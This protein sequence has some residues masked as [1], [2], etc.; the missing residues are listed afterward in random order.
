MKKIKVKYMTKGRRTTKITAQ[1]FM[2][3]ARSPLGK[4]P[5]KVGVDYLRPGTLTSAFTL[6]IPANGN[7]ELIDCQHNREML[8]KITKDREVYEDIKSYNNESGKMDVKRKKVTIA[9]SY[10]VLDDTPIHE[11]I[12]TDNP[13][14]ESAEVRELKAKIAA[15]EAEKGNTPVIEPV[16]KP[17][18]NA[19]PSGDVALEFEEDDSAPLT[20]EEIKS[21]RFSNKVAPT[22]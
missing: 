16:A 1:G 13:L 18:P 21:A 8:R 10:Q 5:L 17:A 19:T 20:K 15:M 2:G 22:K 14:G 3:P 12:V 4:G 7:F 11:D 9:A 6:V